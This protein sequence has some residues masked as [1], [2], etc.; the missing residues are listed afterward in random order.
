MRVRVKICGITDPVSLEAA[1]D[2]GA[3]AI[4]FVFAASE[5]RVE[6]HRAAEL[7]SALPAFVTSV[8]VFRHPTVP[9]LQSMAA[10]FQP[11]LVQAEPGRDVLNEIS[12]S[13]LLPVFHDSDSLPIRVSNYFEVHSGAKTILLEGPGRGGRGVRPD[14]SRATQVSRLG[15]L[16]LAGG[17]NPEN[18]GEAIRGVRPYG[19]DVSSGVESSPGVKDPARIHA[20]LQ[21][22]RDA[23]AG[24]VQEQTGSAAAL[25]EDGLARQRSPLHEDFDR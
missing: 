2:A 3:D 25:D 18:V 6:P 7:A 21:A 19:V 17:L 10:R 20:F 14:W 9:E 22:V 4:G 23:E 24:L 12:R 1:V 15:R 13:R 8:A 11:H 16:I 5:R